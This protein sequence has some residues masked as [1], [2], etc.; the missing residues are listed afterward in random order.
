MT[1]ALSIYSATFPKL[2]SRDRLESDWKIIT[3]QHDPFCTL[4]KDSLVVQ[5]HMMK[6]EQNKIKTRLSEASGT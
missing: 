1:L 6:T 5:L 3:R 2:L 4:W